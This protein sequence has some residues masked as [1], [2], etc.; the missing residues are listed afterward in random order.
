M[1]AKAHDYSGTEDCNKNIKACEMVGICTAE[2][3]VMIR[4]FDKFQRMT[5]LLAREAK[6]KDESLAD[7]I[8]DAR[9]YLAI[10][11]DLLEEK[12]EA[13]KVSV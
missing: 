5:N 2:Q 3:G 4:L 13:N 6:V 10:L 7:T 8:H 1:E 11:A 9:N 12:A